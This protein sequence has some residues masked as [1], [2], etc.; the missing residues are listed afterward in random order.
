MKFDDRTLILITDAFR[1]ERHV[2]M[3]ERHKASGIAFPKSCLIKDGSH[4][5]EIE[6]RNVLL[7]RTLYLGS[8][9]HSLAEMKRGVYTNTTKA[10]IFKE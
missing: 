10:N 1:A 3:Q 6:L 2:V 7:E 8:D 9:D 4:T 5:G